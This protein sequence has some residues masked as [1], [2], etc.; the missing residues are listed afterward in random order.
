MSLA[1]HTPER[2][3]EIAA[4]GG[5]AVQAMGLGNRFNA[6]TGRAAALKG[7]AACRA[8]HGVE[9]FRRIG[10]LGGRAKKNAPLRAVHFAR[11]NG[12]FTACAKRA[13]DVP[14]TSRVGDVTCKPCRK[15]L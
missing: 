9:H 1:D 3:R 2:R 14:H 8:K 11:P 13:A 12:V 4:M 6:D 10:Q 5:R 15:S 7:G